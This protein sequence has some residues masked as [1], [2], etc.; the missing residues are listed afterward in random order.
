MSTSSKPQAPAPPPK[1]KEFVPPSLTQLFVA[2]VAALLVGV[3]NV[4]VSDKV[5]LG[6]P[7]LLVA[8][9]VVLL[10]P[11]V[12]AAISERISLPYHIARLLALVLLGVLGI[13]LIASV[14]LLVAHIPT[15]SGYDLLRSGGLLWAANVLVFALWY[16]ETDGNGPPMRL[17]NCYSAA[18]FQF[19]QQVN[20]NPTNWAPGFVD[21]LFLAFCT[22]SA[23]SPADVMPLTRRAKGLMMLQAVISMVIIVLLVARS[24]NIIGQGAP[25]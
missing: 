18:D 23:L 8:I 20:G 14:V 19:P 1:S 3:I 10:A 22:S 6:P 25:G 24:V 17:E 13:S 5:V 16:W 21:Y 2:M 7:W 9:E 15:L 12:I 11:V 4:F